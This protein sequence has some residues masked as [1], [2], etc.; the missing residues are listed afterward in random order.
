MVS[1]DTR[2]STAPFLGLA[3]LGLLLFASSAGAAE[4]FIQTSN[5]DH[6]WIVKRLGGDLIETYTPHKG[7]QEPELTWVDEVFPSW[8]IRAK[9]AN[10]YVRYG[11]YADVWADT[12]IDAS[13]NPRIKPGAAG[14]LDP[15]GDFEILEI[16]T[17]PVDRRMGDLHVFGNPHYLLDPANAV[18]VAKKTAEWLIRLMPAH[19]AEIEAN[20]DSF[21]GELAAKIKQWDER[22]APLRGKNL[23]SYHRTW[24]YLAKRWGLR[25]VGVIEP[26]PG[27]EP[28]VRDVEVLIA[29]MKANPAPV[30][31]K[32]P[33]YSDKW[34]KYVAE[35]AGYPVKIR[36]LVAHVGGD[37]RVK[38]YFDLF[39]YLIDNLLD[40]YGLQ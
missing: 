28:T 34:P 37:E 8:I 12:L 11:L 16:P 27:I 31:I 30:I 7:F 21:L 22:A 14:Y 32:V 39:D 25:V 4:F 20:L 9:R 1:S 26:K 15:T 40:L 33:V 6:A 13:G 23:V 2:A 18:P 3:L 35:R 5:V 10:G 24:S 17:G 29:A 36:T 19:K 38:T